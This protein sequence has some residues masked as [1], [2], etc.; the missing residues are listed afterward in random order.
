MVTLFVVSSNHSNNCLFMLLLLYFLYCCCCYFCCCL[1]VIIMI[2]TCILWCLLI[3]VV[4]CNFQ[5]RLYVGGVEGVTPPPP[6]ASS[7]SAKSG[8][9]RQKTDE[10]SSFY[11]ISV[12]FL[13]QYQLQS[14]NSALIP[15]SV[16]KTGLYTPSPSAPSAGPGLTLYWR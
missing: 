13:Y 5:A 15:T 10:L 1:L 14:A 9:S 16:G 2:Y 4:V 11:E 7:E 6:R 3:I 8:K 12:H